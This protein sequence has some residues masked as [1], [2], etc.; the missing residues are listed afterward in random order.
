MVRY[1]DDFCWAYGRRSLMLWLVML[2]PAAAF[3]AEPQAMKPDAVGYRDI[4]TPFLKTH[5]VKCHGPEKK[6]GQLR[7]DQQLKNE[8]LDPASKGKWGEVVNV[9]NSHEMPPEGEPQPKPEKVARVVDSGGAD[10]A[11]RRN[12]LAAAQSG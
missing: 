12:R 5:C 6:E 9:L 2:V 3:A 11:R 1:S 8:F 4:I 7:V 10:S